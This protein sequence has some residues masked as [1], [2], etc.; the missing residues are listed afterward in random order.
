[1]LGPVTRL[2]QCPIFRG[3]CCLGYVR[4]SRVLL[5]LSAVVARPIA[6]RPKGRA[7]RATLGWRRRFAG[8]AV[9]E[10]AGVAFGVVASLILNSSRQI[11]SFARCPGSRRSA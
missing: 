5:F 2:T 11:A 3:R 8:D 9:Q 10:A 4:R 7:D 1:V 6:L